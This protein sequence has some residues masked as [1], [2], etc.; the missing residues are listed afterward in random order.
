M[1]TLNN[2]NYQIL[3]K[4]H[5]GDEPRARAAWR[6]ILG[7]GG[8]GDVPFEYEG[9]LDVQSLR[10]LV[11]E[12]KQG[13]AQAIAMNLAHTAIGGRPQMMNVPVPDTATDLEDRIKKIEDIASG[14]K[15]QEN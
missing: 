4:Q 10:V 12:R 2:V 6:Q 5:N 14:D 1:T 13:Q 7:L 8:F 11:D 9:G 3:L 15:P